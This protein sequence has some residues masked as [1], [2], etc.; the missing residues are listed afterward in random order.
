MY[1]ILILAKICTF[2]RTHFLSYAARGIFAAEVLLC[3]TRSDFGYPGWK[4]PVAFHDRGRGE[5]RYIV[6]W[7]VFDVPSGRRRNVQIILIHRARNTS[8]NNN[9]FLFIFFLYRETKEK[10]KLHVSTNSGRPFNTFGG[11]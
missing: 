9:S 6:R 4:T 5:P 10:K 11:D 8:N 1:Y 7:R 2:F 3:L